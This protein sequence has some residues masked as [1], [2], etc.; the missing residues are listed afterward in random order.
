MQ[1]TVCQA[2]LNILIHLGAHKKN[3]FCRCYC[4]HF[5]G[6]KTGLQICQIYQYIKV[7]FSPRLQLVQ[8]YKR[9][10]IN[11]LKEGGEI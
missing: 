2:L 11:R 3:I 4:P 5:T 7:V 9:S 8:L 6:M 10:V 1:H